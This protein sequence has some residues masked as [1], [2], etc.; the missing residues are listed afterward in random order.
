QVPAVLFA[1]VTIVISPLISLMQD[2]VAQLKAQGIAAEYINNSVAWEQQKDTYD[3]L[4]QGRLKLLYVAP[5]KAL[6]RDFIDRISNCNIS[7][8]AIDEA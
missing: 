4:F 7:L 3:A 6:Q 1:G 2:Q 8:F 5:E